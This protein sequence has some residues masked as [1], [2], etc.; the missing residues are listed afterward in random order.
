MVVDSAV[1]KKN[2]DDEKEFYTPKCRFFVG[3]RLL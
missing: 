2:E 3:I 1:L